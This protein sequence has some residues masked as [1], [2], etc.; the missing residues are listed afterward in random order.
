MTDIVPS[1]VGART[2]TRVLTDPADRDEQIHRAIEVAVASVPAGPEHD[3]SVAI[4]V[5]RA[6]DHPSQ[7]YEALRISLAV[8]VQRGLAAAL[9]FCGG[10]II[11][12][13]FVTDARP[14][15]WSS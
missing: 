11:A 2:E 15:Y 10:A 4:S 1:G 7:A 13:C 8:A 14:D 3:Q 9:F 6:R 12:A 5:A